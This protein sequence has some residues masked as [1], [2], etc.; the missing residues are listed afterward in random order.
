[1][2][3]SSTRSSSSNSELICQSGGSNLEDEGSEYNDL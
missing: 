2:Y 3:T 1:M